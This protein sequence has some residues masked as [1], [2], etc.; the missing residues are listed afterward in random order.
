MNSRSSVAASLCEA[1]VRNC[2]AVTR[3][4]HRAAAT[5]R[6]ALAAAFLLISQSARAV[7]V[8]EEI[9]EQKY[10]CDADVT[11]SIRDRKSVV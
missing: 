7:E 9:V 1:H 8:M 2:V 6:I 5:A 3:A 10:P 4:A 11:L